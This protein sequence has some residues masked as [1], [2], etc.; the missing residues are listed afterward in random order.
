MPTHSDIPSFH[1][2]EIFVSYYEIAKSSY[3]SHDTRLLI[4]EVCTHTLTTLI[5][6]HTTITPHHDTPLHVLV[7]IAHCLHI[8][9]TMSSFPG[10]NSSPV[11]WVGSRNEPNS[12]KGVAINHLYCHYF[13][14]LLCSFLWTKLGSNLLTCKYKQ[15]A[16]VSMLKL[17]E[18]LNL[19]H[20]NKMIMF[21]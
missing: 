15:K 14:W 9:S 12:T 2:G 19:P 3:V 7:V 1:S 11:L 6:S 4:C 17:F 5:P 16:Q 8:Y 18:L 10:P 13:H 21:T 20:S